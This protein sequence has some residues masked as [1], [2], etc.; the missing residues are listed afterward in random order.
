MGQQYLK[1]KEIITE[2]I[3]EKRI[4]TKLFIKVKIRKYKSSKKLNLW[5]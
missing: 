3:N 1:P 5:N 2:N 4:I